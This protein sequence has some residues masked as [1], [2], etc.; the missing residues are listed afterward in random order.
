[1]SF[2]LAYYILLLLWLVF[3]LAWN[4]PGSSAVGPYGPIGN[5]VLLFLLFLLLGL[6]DFGAPIHG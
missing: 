1:M 2:G 4:W 3:G 5:S 6:H